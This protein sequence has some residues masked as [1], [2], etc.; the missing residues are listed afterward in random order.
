VRGRLHKAR[1][2]LAYWL[3]EAVRAHL[4]VKGQAALDDEL[5]DLGLFEVVD[6]YRPKKSP[7]F[8]E[9]NP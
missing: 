9:H 6:H 5:R 2:E 7:E 3:G 1:A 4:A 8:R